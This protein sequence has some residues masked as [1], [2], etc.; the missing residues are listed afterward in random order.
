MGAVVDVKYK[1]W[2]P[3]ETMFELFGSP[4]LVS[5]FDNDLYNVSR[6]TCSLY[7]LA[8]FLHGLHWL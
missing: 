1:E 3:G 5:K 4:E 6:H 8:R 7:M 2:G